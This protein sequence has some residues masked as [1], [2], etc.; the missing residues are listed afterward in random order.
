MRHNLLVCVHKWKWN[1]T[2]S[3]SFVPKPP[4]KTPVTEDSCWEGLQGVLNWGGLKKT[5]L[6]CEFSDWLKPAQQC[7]YFLLFIIDM[8]HWCPCFFSF[9]LILQ[10]NQIRRKFMRDGGRTRRWC[11][12]ALFQ[13]SLTTERSTLMSGGFPQNTDFSAYSLNT[14]CTWSWSQSL[15]HIEDNIDPPCCWQ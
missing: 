8:R 2:L 12:G 14:L 13:V 15:L 7:F 4:A 3:S 1:K 6:K 5:T 9:A 10:L 11:R